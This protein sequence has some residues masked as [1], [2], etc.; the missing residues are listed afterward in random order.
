MQ[1]RDSAASTM[2]V[3]AAPVI[4]VGGPQPNG[5]ALRL[6]IRNSARV[7]EEKLRSREDQPKQDRAHDT[8]KSCERLGKPRRST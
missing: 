3:P 2:R 4:A 7:A 1:L 6:R 5:P 8:N